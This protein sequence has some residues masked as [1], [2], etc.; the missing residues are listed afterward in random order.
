VLRHFLAILILPVTVL[1]VVPGWILTAF[2]P[3]DTRWLPG[4]AMP[5]LFQ[6]FGVLLFITG[7]AFFAWCVALFARIGRGTL[8]PWD[9]TR[10]LVIVGPYRHV[11]NPMISGV[12]AMLGGE[13][14]VSGSLIIAGWLSL[15]LLINHVYFLFSEEPGLVRRFGESYEEYRAAVPRWIPSIKPWSGTSDRA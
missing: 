6:V 1:A 10:R 13:A 9:P 5:S 8:A 15:F 11:R 14:L 12:A 4:S 7:F 3:H 2:A